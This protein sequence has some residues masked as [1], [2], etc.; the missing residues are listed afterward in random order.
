[1]EHLLVGADAPF[2][3]IFQTHEISAVPKG[4]I[5]ELRVKNI[6]MF[7]TLVCKNRICQNNKTEYSNRIFIYGI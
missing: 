2:S 3:I 7:S 1:M 6:L 5:M 4:V